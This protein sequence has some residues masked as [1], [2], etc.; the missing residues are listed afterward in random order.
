VQC[1]DTRQDL[2]FLRSLIGAIAPY[3]V[4]EF[5]AMFCEEPDPSGVIETRCT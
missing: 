5:E 1:D 4:A 2:R 3:A